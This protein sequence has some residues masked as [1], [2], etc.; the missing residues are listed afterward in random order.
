MAQTIAA[1]A[2]EV[3][4]SVPVPATR[5]LAASVL[6]RLAIADGRAFFEPASGPRYVPVEKL[7]EGAMGQVALVEDRDI[8]RRVA[9]KSLL[10]GCDAGQVLRFVDEVRL[11]GSLDH[12]GIVPIHD[13]GLDEQGE[14][15]FV[16]K[17]VDGE[18][19]DAVLARLRA[20][21]PKTI[22][23]WDTARRVEVVVAVLRALSYAHARG[24]LHRDV[25]PANIMIG[26]FGEVTLMDWGV[27]RPSGREGAGA[28]ASDPAAEPES[29]AHHGSRASCTTHGSIV[30]TPLYMSPEQARG[31]TET[32]GAR[33][34]LYAASVLLHEVL[35]ERHP[36]EGTDDVRVLLAQIL[37]FRPSLSKLNGPRHVPVEYMHF[38]VRGLAPKP[39]DRWSSADEMVD[40]LH[41]IL[42]GR[43]RVQCPLTF[44]RRALGSLTRALDRHPAAVLL[45]LAT[46]LLVFIGLLV[47]TARA[48]LGA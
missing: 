20:R 34:D 17:Y 47:T 7:G 30:G 15:F 28:P 36:H 11:V 3:S 26:R 43:C 14:F 16:M 8:G 1:P 5:T 39:E 19:L 45:A 23:A 42:D 25:K 48:A 13:V 2:I 40:E 38:L 32:L 6:P 46:T 9:R 4:G 12:P 44:T 24:I 10:P 18:T 35:F 29:L 33:S 22:A 21:D 37:A 27:A 41:A 31:E